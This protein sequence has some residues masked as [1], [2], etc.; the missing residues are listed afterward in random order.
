ML[1]I[2]PLRPKKFGQHFLHDRGCIQHI[3]KHADFKSNDHVIEIGPGGGALTEHLIP[4]VS[5]LIAIEIDRDLCAL[6]RQKWSNYSE[7]FHLYEADALSFDF[8]QLKRPASRSFRMIGNLAYNI[9]TPL[10]FHLVQYRHIFHDWHVMLQKEVAN[11]LVAL[12]HHTN[13][14]RLS[15]MMQ[16][17]CQIKRLFVV[18]PGA[19][20]PPPK[21]DSAI[22]ALIPWK[23][24]PTKANDE[25]LFA[26]LV[27]TSFSHRR[28]T[29][30]NNLRPLEISE[31]HLERFQINPKSR[32]QEL[33]VTDYV[34]LANSLTSA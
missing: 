14:G 30:L 7:K 4:L 1:T 13:Y 6:L 20:T 32:A 8:N 28:K 21:V 17:Y 5:E 16:Y 12:P 25:A 19:F 22:V 23:V 18:R 31:S 27:K 10:L 26:R 11:R 3:L 29:I 2:K 15:V 9:A 33:S 24:L 34:R